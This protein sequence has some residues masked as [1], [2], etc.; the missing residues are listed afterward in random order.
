MLIS[1]SEFNK[2][3]N[4]VGRYGQGKTM[5]K[6]YSDNLFQQDGKGSFVVNGIT[7]IG[8]LFLTL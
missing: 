2:E 7:S 5:P 6:G 1:P 3:G 8:N 4:P